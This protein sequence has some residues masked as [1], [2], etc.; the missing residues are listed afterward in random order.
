MSLVQ[1]GNDLLHLLDYVFD[2]PSSVAVNG[3]GAVKR[4][5]IAMPVGAVRAW[6]R[7]YSSDRY[8]FVESFHHVIPGKQIGG[9]NWSGQI[10]KHRG[11]SSSVCMETC[12]LQIEQQ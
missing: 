7:C 8:D 10:A 12:P 3:F 4:D 9:G 2:T 5:H 11:V 6:R 1:S